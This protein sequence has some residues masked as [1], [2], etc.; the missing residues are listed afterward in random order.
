MQDIVISVDPPRDRE[1]GDWWFDIVGPGIN[2]T[3]VWMPRQGIGIYERDE[4]SF[5][6]P[7]FV[8]PV[9]TTIEQLVILLERHAWVRRGRR[10]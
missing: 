7:D 10:S 8:L 4:R 6:K 2:L 1:K 5:T 3:A 9:D